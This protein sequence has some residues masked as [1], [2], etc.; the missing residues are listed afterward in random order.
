MV[1]GLF[2]FLYFQKKKKKLKNL[3]YI[4]ELGPLVLVDRSYES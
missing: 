2:V 4:P 1:L 3:D